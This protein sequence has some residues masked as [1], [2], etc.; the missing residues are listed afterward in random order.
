MNQSWLQILEWH[1]IERYGKIAWNPYTW[2]VA[3]NYKKR[4]RFRNHSTADR[5]LLGVPR[6]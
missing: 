2:V 5:W 6:A 4:K 3:D 1:T